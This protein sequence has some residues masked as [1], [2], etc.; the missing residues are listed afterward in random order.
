MEALL[1]DLGYAV[2]SLRRS[3]GFM[4]VA[5][6]TLA[7]GIAAPTVV[8]SLINALLLRPLPVPAP[9]RLVTLEEV[10]QGP[11]VRVMGQAAYPFERYLDLREQAGASFSGLAAQ[12][13]RDVSIRADGSAG[14]VNGVVVSANYFDVLGI[15]PGAGRF[16]PADAERLGAEPVAVIS[17]ALWQERFGGDP[18]VVGRTVHLDSQPV[19]V[20]GVAPADFTGT[21]VGI[22]ASVWVPVN[23]LGQRAAGEQ[24][25]DGT[26]WVGV[27]GRLRPGVSV[28]QA[29]AQMEVLVRRLPADTIQSRFQ[30]VRI[31]AIS[32]VPSG[33]RAPAIG[34]TA[35]LLVT[36][37][38]VLLI[39]SSNVAGMLLARAVTRQRE[40]AI[41]LA[42]GAG[43]GRLVGQLLT[44]SLVLF[45]LAGG[46]GLLLTVALTRL[47]S[48]YDPP[49]PMQIHLDLGVDGRV[50]A[51][52]LAVALL[53]GVAAGLTPA[54]RGTR[55]DLVEG[56]KS[57]D[58]AKAT[59]RT[60]LRSAFV[61]GQLAMS[62]L[63]L[64]IAGLFG[65]TLRSALAMDPGFDAEGIVVAGV[66]LSAHGYDEARA[67]AAYRQLTE[68]LAASDEVQSVSLARI[69]PLGGD[70]LGGEIE[71]AAGDG[72]ST[73]TEADFNLVDPSYFSTMRLA[74]RA[75]REFTASD[76][77]GAP[78]V[79]IVNET[80][81]RRFWPGESPLGKR[82]LAGG[83]EREVVGVTGDGKYGSYRDEEVAFYYLP[84]AQNPSADLT[85][86][87]RARGET[88]PALEA[89]RREMAAIDAN[90]ALQQAMPLKAMLDFMLYPQRMAAALIGVFGLIG[91]LLAGTGIYGILAYHVSQRTREIGIRMALGASATGVLRLVVAQGLTLTGVGIAAGLLV[92]FAATRLLSSMLYGVSATDPLTF[93]GVPLLLAAV[94]ALASYLPARRAVRV[95]PMVA[96]RSE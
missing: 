7:V 90:V 72:A 25:L 39:A 59:G 85:V 46:A 37:A 57:G 1:Q 51:F 78:P 60:R 40:M 81:A 41:R 19:R 20:I 83:Q 21:M 58:A 23:A 8:F 11:T 22:T 64:V 92:A 24:V 45:L 10:R 56:L 42:I 36:A 13:Y 80:L 27:F 69:A 12:R 77:A 33:L 32:R 4:L 62:L 53:T 47:I 91:L 16:F 26:E 70:V 52:T 15:R 96:L 93:I 48:S 5:T 84:L 54:L 66:A 55:T 44:E 61:V 34:F 94:A 38:L 87:V 73:R 35:M 50:M 49:T 89:I 28:E 74:V 68:R 88:A 76:R 71:K 82:F 9:E 3:P 86:H 75:G 95:D 43:R 31:E 14:I 63:L 2:R 67:D 30:G 6:L 65:R 79:A 18:S 29:R 17:H